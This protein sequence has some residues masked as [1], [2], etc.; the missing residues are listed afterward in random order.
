MATGDAQ[1]RSQPMSPTERLCAEL[2]AVNTR[3]TECLRLAAAGEA[4]EMGV[5]AWRSTYDRKLHMW[6]EQDARLRGPRPIEPAELCAAQA[7]Y[8][9]VRDDARD[10]RAA[11]VPLRARDKQLRDQL[12]RIG[13]EQT[14]A[15][16]RLAL[17]AFRLLLDEIRPGATRAGAECRRLQREH[18][19]LMPELV[20]IVDEIKQSLF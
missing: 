4:A 15:D 7:E 18:P 2:E 6:S 13:A 8:M 5:R 20:R 9:R 16:C 3:L 10:A 17:A 11:I 12:A 14:E 19:T 1:N